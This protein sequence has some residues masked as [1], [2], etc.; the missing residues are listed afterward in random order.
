[1]GVTQVLVRN[2]VSDICFIILV[3][4]TSDRLRHRFRVHSITCKLSFAR[5]WDNRSEKQ[6]LAEMKTD[7][8]KW[9]CWLSVMTSSTPGAPIIMQPQFETLKFCWMCEILCSVCSCIYAYCGCNCSLVGRQQLF[10][11]FYVYGSVHHNIFY[12]ITNRCSY[13]QSILFHC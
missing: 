3:V 6:N 7:R 4:N 2:H 11:A 9:W 5:V 13:V 1:M 12:E 8:A 10:F